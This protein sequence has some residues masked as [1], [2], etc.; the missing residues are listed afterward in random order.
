ANGQVAV[1]VSGVFAGNGD[2]GA[3]EG[4]GGIIFNIQEVGATQVVIAIFHTGGDA[5]SVDNRFDIAFF[6]MLRVE[7]ELAAHP[8]EAATNGGHHHVAYGEVGAAVGRVKFPGRHVKSLQIS[9]LIVKWT[10]VRL[11]F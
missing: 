2:I 10:T 3:L 4:D 11:R 1:H 6:R 7:F 9:S 5:R 8:I